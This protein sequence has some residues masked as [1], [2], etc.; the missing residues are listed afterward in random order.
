MSVLERFQLALGSHLGTVFL[1]L[2]VVLTSLL[3]AYWFLVVRQKRRDLLAYLYR[4]YYERAESLMK[5]FSFVGPHKAEFFG[6]LTNV[7]GSE[8]SSAICLIP[9]PD[10]AETD[11]C[12]R[13]RCFRRSVSSTHFPHL[14]PVLWQH[15]EDSLC[16]VQGGTFNREGRSL[17]SLRQHL[18]DRQLGVADREEILL[19]IATTLAQLHEHESEEGGGLYHGMLLPR[20][21]YVELD[22][23]RRL[24][25]LLI[26][27]TGMAFSAGPQLIAEKLRKL[28]EGTLP[29]EKR[30]AH[31]LLEQM[32][33]LAPE[34]RH[35]QSAD[36]VGQAVDFYAFGAL[37][38]VLF[39]QKRF[40][41]PER[42]NWEKVPETWRPFVEQCLKENPDDRPQDFT[43]LEEWLG[44]P[45]LA[46]THNEGVKAASTSETSETEA[47]DRDIDAL[48]GMLE[49]VQQT[50]EESTPD[51]ALSEGI[52]ALRAGRWKSAR[53]LLE[54]LA[55]SEPDNPE[56]AISL[57]IACYELGDMKH[58][59][60]HYVKAKK[61][62]PKLAKRFRRHIA[63]R[64]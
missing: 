25:Q 28:K 27:H 55:K 23:H 7:K 33:M 52:R 44:D 26:A 13:F 62:N 46:L 51:D 53:K 58:A 17:T 20:Y 31:E 37:A 32:I 48:V 1:G 16:L 22:P 57:A 54:K 15:D 49:R 60:T 29:V 24:N 8:G 59:E 64:L 14:C 3:V 41:S 2:V 45:E 61:L 42:V 5:G 50:S 12:E 47:S 36:S 10:L 18:F 21:I 40:V 11:I 6:R 35:E 38:A 4:S 63:F 30:C 9:P 39:T 56:A 34:Q 43:E 19:Q